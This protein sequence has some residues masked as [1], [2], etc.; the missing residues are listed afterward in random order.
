MSQMGDIG[1]LSYEDFAGREGEAFDLRAEGTGPGSLVLVEATESS[2]AGGTS[3]S[4]EQR[5]QFSL[6]FHGP[7]E[8]G[9]TQGTHR[10]THAE[11]GDLELFL[12]PLG[13]DA[14]GMRYEAAF[15]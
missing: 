10:L 8:P 5:Q 2:Q 11:L 3:P 4:G 14:D 1:W 13:P 6:V 15:A 12:V 9:L 7:V